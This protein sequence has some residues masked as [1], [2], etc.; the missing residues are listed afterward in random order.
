MY[1]DSGKSDAYL[2]IPVMYIVK[3]FDR[4]PIQLTALNLGAKGLY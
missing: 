4:K 1:W 3:I 2:A